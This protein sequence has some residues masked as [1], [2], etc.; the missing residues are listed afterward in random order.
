MGIYNLVDDLDMSNEYFE[1]PARVNYRLEEDKSEVVGLIVAGATAVVSAVGGVTKAVL[2]NRPDV[3]KKLKVRC[4]RRPRIGKDRK[5]EY[6]TC[7]NGFYTEILQDKQFQQEIEQQKL[8]L[9][10][11]Q[12]E[13]EQNKLESESKGLSTGA[14]IG[15]G[16]GVLLLSAV[17]GLVVAKK[18]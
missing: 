14:W 13:L 7:K 9:E 15:I 4:G 10:R 12:L 6:E 1:K 5:T 8:Q 18:K 16:A 2:E 17:V 3:Q 11:G